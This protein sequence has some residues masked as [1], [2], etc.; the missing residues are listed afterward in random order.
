[1]TRMLVS[2]AMA[3]SAQRPEMHML[4]VRGNSEADYSTGHVSSE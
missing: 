3:R 4:D 2:V 1:M